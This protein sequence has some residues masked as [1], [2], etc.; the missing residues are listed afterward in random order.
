MHGDLAFCPDCGFQ[1]ELPDTGPPM[2]GSAGGPGSLGT[3]FNPNQPDQ[4][5][6]RFHQIQAIKVVS[7]EWIAPIRDELRKLTTKGVAERSYHLIRMANR[8]K[9]LGGFRNKLKGLDGIGQRGDRT[10]YRWTLLA[11]SAVDVLSELE[12]HDYDTD[13]L[14]AERGIPLHDRHWAVRLLRPPRAHST[15]T[16]EEIRSQI[17][18]NVDH[19][20][21]QISHWISTCEVRFREM[22]P[23][24]PTGELIGT[25]IGILR[26]DWGQ[27]F[28]DGDPFMNHPFSNHPPR[29][30]AVKAFLESMKI[31]PSFDRSHRKSFWDAFPAK[32]IGWESVK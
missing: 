28:Y 8:S 5:R 6:Q 16:P 30:I 17:Q 20:A 21:K 22:Y 27:P 10:A 18:R 9:P 7:E 12:N 26:H 23:G 32:G 11:L 1:A 14:F 4:Y 25:A 15:D 13:R 19:R 31:H 29:R 24:T 2:F 3:E